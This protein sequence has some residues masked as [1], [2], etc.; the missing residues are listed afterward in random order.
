MSVN[1]TIIAAI[2]ALLLL[3][4]AGAAAAADQT[5]FNGTHTIPG[6][7]QAEDYDNGG[8][9]VAYSDDT[10]ANIGAAGRLTEAVDVR[11]INGVTDIAYIGPGEWTEYTVTVATT[12]TYTANF[13]LAAIATGRQVV[14]TVDGA[15]GCTVTVPNTGGYQT[16]QTVSAPLALTQGTHVVRLTYHHRLYGHRLVP[17][18]R[19]TH[20][21]PDSGPDDR[22]NGPDRL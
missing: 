6:L 14:L 5:P 2:S 20:D 22:F 7:I 1:R 16:Y 3:G 10:T 15:Q 19:C 21:R 13:R 18:Q 12:G 8:T 4:L 9:G 11:L 17:D